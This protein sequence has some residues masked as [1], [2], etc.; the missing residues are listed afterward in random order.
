[1]NTRHDIGVAALIGKYSDAV[2]AA[3][4]SRWLSR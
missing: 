1:M 2:E 3:P 4:G